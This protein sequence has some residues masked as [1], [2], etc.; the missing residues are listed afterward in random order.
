M[1]FFYTVWKI[2][3]LKDSRDKRSRF[4][5]FTGW[6]FTAQKFTE[7]PWRD[8]KTRRGVCETNLR[9][10]ITCVSEIVAFI[11]KHIKTIFFCMFNWAIGWLDTSQTYKI[12]AQMLKYSLSHVKTT[13]PPLC[14]HASTVMRATIRRTL[15]EYLNNLI[16]KTVITT[17][18]RNSEMMKLH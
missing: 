2:H 13:R 8:L 6:K 12:K 16:V 18:C 5:I 1:S 4:K 17:K 11:V 9:S 15:L 14:M 7:W 10:Y 3:G